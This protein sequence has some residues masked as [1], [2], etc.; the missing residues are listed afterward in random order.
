MGAASDLVCRE[1]KGAA[2]SPYHGSRFNGLAQ[3]EDEEDGQHAK[4]LRSLTYT[5]VDGWTISVPAG[6]ETDFA[7][8]PRALTWLI[9]S[10]G[11]YNRP[12]IIHDFLYHYAPADP[13]TGKY[14]TQARAD[15]ILREACENC[16]DLFTQ[17]WA[18]FLGLKI[19]GFVQ[20][21]KYRRAEQPE[22]V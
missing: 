12:A 20:W 18:I 13:I 21:R 3:L 2:V 22:G 11:P 19:G 16:D 10:R 5:T 14:C 15:S 9:P 6:F 17:R 8:I 7:S 4:L 1:G